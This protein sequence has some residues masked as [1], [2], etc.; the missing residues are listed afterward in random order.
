VSSLLGGFIGA[1]GGGA[2]GRAAVELFLDSKAYQTQLAEA[3]GKTKASTGGMATTTA[4]ASAGMV[5]AYAGAGIAAFEFGKT[6]VEA[7]VAA[8]EAQTKL[9]NSVANSS[10]VSFDAVPAFN[11]QAESIARLT[12]TYSENITG[13]QALLVQMGL[14]ENQISTLTP[15]VVDLA[16]KNGVD[17][18]AAFKAVGKAV[19]GST[20][21]LAR[22]V[23]PVTK[24]STAAQ[25]FTNVQEKLG[26]VTGFAA[27][28]AK[29][30]PWRLL[31]ERF[32]EVSVTLGE[33]LLPV[34]QDLTPALASLVG[35]VGTALSPIEAVA[36]ATKDWYGASQDIAAGFSGDT[37]PAVDDLGDRLKHLGSLILFGG[38]AFK[39][40]QSAAQEASIEEVKSAAAASAATAQEAAQH[41]K[42]AQAM[43]D[44]KAAA[45]ELA[46]GTLS[47]IEAL[48]SLQEDQQTINALRRRGKTDSQAYSDAV[49]KELEDQNQLNSSLQD[50]RG[51]LQDAHA[52][53]GA[54]RG[55][56]L[57][58]GHQAG[59]T[60]DDLATLLKSF[61]QDLD[62]SHGKV[63]S[64]R[65]ALNSLHSKRI[66]VDVD[67]FVSAA[68]VANIANEVRSQ[69]VNQAR[70]NGGRTGLDQTKSALTRNSP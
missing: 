65:D 37:G 16:A 8:N 1:A 20:G 2:I 5:A 42:A 50:L 35:V 32:H 52:G 43:R 4:G 21:A 66:T 49:L 58:L 61:N 26:A 56:L 15:L 63:T 54:L 29:E 59:L 31:G 69:L 44:Q 12:G 17:L 40:Q 23:G 36:S 27:Q 39:D 48:K 22:Y 45:D 47:L 38:K 55:V 57:D 33:E 46:G 28:Q 13:G 41:K 24:G 7:A 19:E 3:E 60:R 67:L 68:G 18:N 53:S 70:S 25:T 51:K 10:K 64:L 62:Q 34:V 6:A 11:A 14:T 30:E 9:A